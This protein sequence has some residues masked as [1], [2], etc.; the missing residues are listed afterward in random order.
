MSTIQIIDPCVDERW[1]RFVENHPLGWIVH[2]SGWKKV[3]ESTF[4]HIRGHYLAIADE[5]ASSIEAG[6]PVYEIRSWFTGNR[7]VS[8]PFATIS[9]L[10]IS[11]QSHGEVL[12]EET[13][14]LFTRLNFPYLEVRSSSPLLPGSRKDLDMQANYKYHYLDL[15]DGPDVL[16]KKM[17]YKSIRYE[18]NKA[19]RKN[20]QFRIAETEEDIRSFYR[21]YSMARKRLGLPSQPYLFFKRLYATFSQSDRVAI[22]LALLENRPIAA[23]L[24]FK[25]NGRVSVEAA[26][27]DTNMR[28]LGS[29]RFLYWES[30]KL[31]RSEGYKV[32]DFG[33]TSVF[34]QSLLDSKR[35]WGA[36]ETDLYSFFCY[37]NGRSIN[38]VNSEG[39]AAYRTMRLICKKSPI[40]IQPMISRFCYRHL[41]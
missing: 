32:F 31:A 11:T 15:S 29:S 13:K 10:L 24:L 17:N 21:L 38:P 33:R 8:I 27:D 28:N 41:G 14:R 35:R 3:I 20:I 18:I 22:H 6:L 19:I 30:I 26:G 7:L 25:F 1:D 9:D 40:S 36:K 23:Q 16:W 12:L 39:S 37:K 2:L 34:N 4:P 5:A